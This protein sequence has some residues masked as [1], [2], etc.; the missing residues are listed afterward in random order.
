M[1]AKENKE[2]LKKMIAFAISKGVAKSQMDFGR[3]L[4]YENESSFSQILNKTPISV[5]FA[6]KIK[7]TLPELSLDWIINGEGEMLQRADGVSAPVQ[8]GVDINANSTID[9]ALNEI[10]AQ[11]KMNEALQAKLFELIDKIMK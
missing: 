3:V 6:K 9:K 4:G 10:A 7:E 5:E 8:V 11:R 2:R 1:C